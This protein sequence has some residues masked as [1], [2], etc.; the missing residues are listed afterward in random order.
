MLAKEP[1]CPEEVEYLARW[2]RLLHG[3]SGISMAGVAPLTFTTIH[4]WAQLMHI[5]KLDPLEVEALIM[6]DDALFYREEETN[7]EEDSILSPTPSWP[8]RQENHES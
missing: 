7:Q 1:E 2:A 6:L 3:R 4:R 8:K 5:G